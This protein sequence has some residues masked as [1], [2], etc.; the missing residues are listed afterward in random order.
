M[1]SRFVGT[2]YETALLTIEVTTDGGVTF[3]P[4]DTVVNASSW[5]DYTY[6][7]QDYAGMS[8]VQLAFNFNDLGDWAYGWGIDRVAV[9][10]VEPLQDFQLAQTTQVQKIV[11]TGNPVSVGPT[12]INY[13]AVGST[14][15][16]IAWSLD[17]AAPSM[18]TV[19]VDLDFGASLPLT[20]LVTFVPMSN[21]SYTLTVWIADADEQTT[22]G[23]TVVLTYET[24]MN[25]AKL[26]MV[27]APEVIAVDSSAGVVFRMLN[28]GDASISSWNIYV[29]GVV[30]QSYNLSSP[31]TAT[32]DYMNIAGGLSENAPGAHTYTVAI[33][34]IN[35][36]P[37][38]TDSVTVSI[39]YVQDLPE[40]RFV[41]EE[42][43]GTWCGWC[44]RGFVVI[45]DSKAL[46]GDRFI[47]IAMHGGDPMAHSNV[48]DFR[49]ELG[50]SSFP[51][52]SAQRVT[53]SPLTQTRANAF[54][55]YF[56][57]TGAI[58]TVETTAS[59]DAAT[60][61][62][63]VE[64]TAEFYAESNEE[65]RFVAA[66]T[67]DGVTGTDGGYAQANYYAFGNYGPMGGYENL[68]DPVPASMMVYNHVLREYLGGLR[69]DVGS[70]PATV[71]AGDVVTYTYTYE[72]PADYDL[73]Q[74]HAVGMLTNQT[75][76]GTIVN[77]QSTAVTGTV[78]TTAT[79]APAIEVSVSPNPTDDFTYLRLDLPDAQPV[80]LALY[81]FTGRML[82]TR[83]YGTLSGNT[84]LPMRVGD[85]APGIYMVRLQVGGTTVVKKVQVMR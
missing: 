22:E 3:T 17:G 30:A 11:A 58:A 43:T 16:D 1:T 67:E 5:Y 26:E 23:D 14:D 41:M 38:L 85:L 40:R 65:Y 9:I 4:L 7:L 66:I 61:M 24:D 29:D 83:N 63:T 78:S 35:G 10:E 12:L 51:M 74:L 13:S 72:V 6:V 68:I 21:S 73:S 36:I 57:Q 75:R 32:N 54:Q 64:L 49:E 53:P 25:R 15:L 81:D 48:G 8:N 60:R 20:D 34:D 44:P 45:E 62:V 79:L 55:E 18:T 84:V 82:M 70:V 77:A 80:Q 56:D 59:V 50:M 42:L 27:Y 2:I 69:G 33:G 47:P 28:D 46:Y 37:G 31:V 52:M 76:G 19:S 39:R 71:N